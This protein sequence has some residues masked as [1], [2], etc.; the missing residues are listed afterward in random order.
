VL[1][2]AAVIEPEPLT[3]AQAAEYLQA[4]MP[5]DPGPSW[6][7]VLDRIRAGTAEHLAR[8]VA[9]PLGLWLLRAVYITPRADP[10][11]LLSSEVARDAAAM[12]AHLFDQLIPAVLTTHPASGNPND[13]FRPR[14][15]WDAAKVRSW[16][17]YLAQHLDRTGTRDL[18]WWHVARHTFSRREFGL[19]VGL[20]VGLVAALGVGLAYGWGVGLWIGLEAGLV[21]GPVTGLVAGLGTSLRR[22]DWLTDEPAYANLRLKHRTGMLVRDLGAGLGTALAAGLILGLGTG[23]VAG[24]RLGLTGG[25]AFGLLFGLVVGLIAGLVVELGV[26]LV[27]GLMGAL[28]FGLEVG[29]KVRLEIG[30]IV[31]L[32]G[33]LVIGLVKWVGTP[34]RTGWASTP[35]STYKATRALLAVQICVGVLVGGLLG[36]LVGGLLVGAP[37]GQAATR[38]AHHRPANRMRGRAGGRTGGRAGADE[39]RRLAQ[40]HPDFI[41]ACGHRK[42]AAS[43]HGL[44]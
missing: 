1:T 10:R 6:R 44:P 8:V 34:S 13:R 21:T 14:R 39:Q 20:A 17:T 33:G 3:S 28:G 18:L 35:R 7:D 29:L 12:Q 24:L 41:L 31:G 25:L 30:L 40:L 22:H 42:A 38:R 27:V 11:P 43:A 37:A 2:A 9:T 26:G 32:G 15:S 19:V 5:P 4:C 16:L 36:G 23:L